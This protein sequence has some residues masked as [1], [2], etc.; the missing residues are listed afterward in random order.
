MSVLDTET[1]VKI[2]EENLMR[3]GWVRV[4]LARWRKSITIK[5]GGNSKY[6]YDFLAT[7]VQQLSVEWILQIPFTEHFMTVDD[8]LTLKIA[9]IN[10]IENQGYECIRY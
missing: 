7:V 1:D 10:S 4:S 9:I 5:M 2:T 8:M 6:T 3:D